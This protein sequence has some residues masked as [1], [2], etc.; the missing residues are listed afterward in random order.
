M[1]NDEGLKMKDDD[2]KLLKGFALWQTNGRT[3]SSSIQIIMK[4]SIPGLGIQSCYLQYE[5]VLLE[6]QTK[7][8]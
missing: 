8:I 3:Y 2:F 5:F 1:K 4:V 6:C 7:I